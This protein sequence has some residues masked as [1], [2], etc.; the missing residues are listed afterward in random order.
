MAPNAMDF[1]TEELERLFSRSG[2]L[3]SAGEL[4]CL[5][6]RASQQTGQTAQARK[7]LESYLRQSHAAVSPQLRMRLQ[8]ELAVLTA[9]AD[10]QFP[11]AC[12]LLDD[13]LGE[14][15]LGDLAGSALIERG[16]CLLHTSKLAAA[17]KDIRRGLGFARNQ[18]Q[19][20]NIAKG[21][22]YLG[23]VQSKQNDPVALEEA[24]HHLMEAARIA[25]PMPGLFSQIADSLGRAF[26]RRGRYDLAARWFSGSIKKKRS[27]GDHVGM[28]FSYGGLGE[29]HLR[30]GHFGRAARTYEED[31][32]L[33]RNS[34][35]V[36]FLQVGQ[37]LCLLS[38][39][40]RRQRK[41]Q[42]ARDLLTEARQALPHINASQRPITRGYIDTYN[43]RICSDESQYPE[44]LDLFAEAEQNFVEA[45]YEAFLPSVRQ[46]IG[47]VQIQLGNLD[48]A[49]Q[50]LLWA[51]AHESDPYE[52]LFIYESLTLLARLQKDGEKAV[53]YEAQRR[54]LNEQLARPP[55]PNVELA[56]LPVS[57]QALVP[58]SSQELVP[59]SRELV[60]LVSLEEAERAEIDI[61][62][63]VPTSVFASE[64][65]VVKLQV[66][67]SSGP[68]L[69][70]LEL[71]LASDSLKQ[72]GGTLNPAECLKTDSLGRASFEICLGRRE[73]LVVVEIR[74]SALPVKTEVVIRAHD[75]D[76]SS[77]KGCRI[78]ERVV[79]L[80]RQMF[81]KLAR[82]V[83][84]EKVTQRSDEV[85]FLKVECNLSR[86]MRGRRKAKLLVKTGPEADIAAERDAH[87]DHMEWVKEA[88][89]PV[90]LTET[91]SDGLGAI[92]YLLPGA[93]ASGEVLPLDQGM[94]DRT[95]NEI[96][97]AIETLFTEK[98]DCLYREPRYVSDVMAATYPMAA[99]F[100]ATS[101]WSRVAD[102]FPPETLRLDA[103]GRVVIKF[104][105]RVRV[106]G[107][108]ATYRELTNETRTA[109]KTRVHGGVTTDN[110]CVDKEG[111]PWLTDW[112]SFDEGHIF[113]DF[114]TLEIDVRLK[115]LRS[116]DV[117][118]L[119]FGDWYRIEGQM[120]E[121]YRQG[122]SGSWPPVTTLTRGLESMA[123]KKAYAAV[124]Q[125]RR[126][127]TQYL[128]PADQTEYL[129][130]LFCYAVSKM[131]ESEGQ[132]EIFVLLSLAVTL[133]V[134]MQ[135]EMLQFDDLVRLKPEV[136]AQVFEMLGVEHA[137]RL[138]PA[139][140]DR[141]TRKRKQSKERSARLTEEEEKKKEQEE[142]DEMRKARD[143]KRV[144]QALHGVPREMF[145]KL[146][147]GVSE[148][149]RGII[150]EDLAYRQ[151]EPEDAERARREII[152]IVKR[153]DARGI[154]LFEEEEEQRQES[155]VL[156]LGEG[157][158]TKKRVRRKRDREASKRPRRRSRSGR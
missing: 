87:N 41:L 150:F 151:V 15:D 140:L 107:V 158:G 153:M 77:K 7:F 51:E 119:K 57:S 131:A 82:E 132:Q 136:V 143:E 142:R 89:L 63:D 36:N 134:T 133:M 27:L 98:L 22:Q 72:Q 96:H 76:I 21:L 48:A 126:V 62:D 19:R 6:A 71:C 47:Q 25:K 123:L 95:Y 125:T 91:A 68:P 78:P 16:F 79:P 130:G 44:A 28:A 34:S 138:N 146:M 90:I 18:N 135:R 137:A 111:R 39:C 33:V 106:P 127:S 26:S 108:F 5:M 60:P 94:K 38:E 155:Q 45:E 99:G 124:V 120:L 31:L 4:A 110:L 65:V 61:V 3:E 122:L 139:A 50:V 81:Y 113:Y 101:F 75:V 17:E 64:T 149:R 42:P 88:E 53:R 40:N 43:A 93:A 105:D 8:L 20:L 116:R 157:E 152:N 97:R 37:V 117:S 112:S 84:V 24:C 11:R 32:K 85:A 67:R 92:A 103:E 154:D 55:V 9:H 109:Q 83:E 49:E 2:D 144:L 23:M 121:A 10:Y 114:I 129:R 80:L 145:D 46:G 69:P 29:A 1:S 70:G 30:A 35:P 58:V 100:E 14:A 115:A 56:P 66:R 59:V 148:R 118:P 86:E 52:Q 54:F 73:G 147:Y 141:Q 12:E 156:A 74:A 128:D 102:R 13:L 104:P